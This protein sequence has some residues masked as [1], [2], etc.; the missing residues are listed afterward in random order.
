[1]PKFLSENIPLHPISQTGQNFFFDFLEWGKQQHEYDTAAIHRHQ[2]YELIFFE[3]G[4]GTHEI[5]FAPHKVMAPAIHFLTIGKAHRVALKAPYSGFSLLFSEAFLGKE[6][7][8]ISSMPFF[9]HQNP[10]PVLETTPENYAKMKAWLLEIKEAWRASS[11]DRWEWIRSHL[12]LILLQAQRL[13]IA[14]NAGTALHKNELVQRFLE[15]VEKHHLD[16]WLLQQYAMEL[17]IT[18]P[19]LNVLCKKECGM[20][21]SQIIQE[22]LVQAAKRKLAYTTD[23]IKTIAFDLNFNDPSYFIRFFKKQ[24]GSSPSAYRDVLTRDM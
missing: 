21:A 13:Y 19:H 5:D 7:L 22:K 1:M 16:H 23:S 24:V 14:E 18:E 10:Y 11:P 4:E 20:P 8:N 2:Y 6:N 17:C 12:A 9:Q 3:S 15:L